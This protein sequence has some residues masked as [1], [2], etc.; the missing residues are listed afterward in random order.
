MVIKKLS[1][2]SQLNNQS[3]TS[4]M[5]NVTLHLKTLFE[6]TIFA[7]KYLKEIVFAKIFIIIGGS[8]Q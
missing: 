6:R 4:A 8:N 5:K 2:E 7:G 1:Q 3:P